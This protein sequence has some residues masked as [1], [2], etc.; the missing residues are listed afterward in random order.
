MISFFQFFTQKLRLS[1]PWR[2]KVPLLISF[3]Y[4]LL[5]AGNVDSFTSAMSFF[6]AIATTIGFMGFGYLTND[7]A[8]RKK[9][10]LA[11]KSNGTANLS[12]G[13]ISMLVIAFLAI[14]ILPWLY[15]PLDEVSAIC[16]FT[17]LA[18]FVL[19]AFPPFRLKERGILGVLTDS[20]YAHV[21][22]GF[23]ASWTFFLVGEKKYDD[24]Y[25]FAG[26]LILW[27]LISGTR[28]IVSHHFKDFENDQ[29][30]GTNT[31]AT[32]VGKDRVYT[33]MSR[34]LI[35]LEVIAFVAFLAVI[36]M[37]VGF[38]FAVVIVFLAFATINYR[39]GDSDT[40]AK[41]F[42]N[43][44]LD[45]FYIHWFPYIIIFTLL[46]SNFEFWW[47][48]V[49]H[50]LLF[51]PFIGR[52]GHRF[53]SKK[54]MSSSEPK[55]EKF[56]ILSTNRNKYSETFIQ[57]HIRLI[58]EVVVYSD[59]YFP[60]SISLDKGKSWKELS[61]ENNPENALIQSWKEQNV[62]AVLAEYGPAGA[63]VMHACQKANLPLIVHFH[64]FDAYREDALNHYGEQYKELFQLA[65]KIMVVSADMKAQL[66]RLGCPQEKLQQITY[67]VDTDVFT[68]PDGSV[69]RKN[70]IACGRF[71]PKKAPLK[72]IQ[73][74]AKV[75]ER[76]PDAK[77]TFVGE[78][79]LLN[80]A[81][82]LTKEL[83]LENQI[84]FKGILSPREVATELQSHA[85][86]VQHSVKTDQNDS[87]GTPLS[88]LEAAATGLAIVST[89]HAGIPEV[90][91]DGKSGYLVQ[92]GDV[93][94]MA[95]RMI[96]LL[97]DHQLRRKFG[98]NARAT[99]VKK[100]GQS[101]YIA[102]LENVLENAEVPATKE[103]RLS[104]WKKRLAVFAVLF[105]LAEIGLRF[106]GYNPG[107][108]E[109][110]Y[111]HK[112]EVVYD[113]ILYADEVGIT[114]IVPGAQ[115]ITD[116]E[117]NTE[118]FMSAVE[119]S[120]ESVEAIRASGQ[121]IVM[122][123]GDSYT[124]G[125]C[126]DSY[127]ASFA[128]LLNQSEEYAVLNFGIP[129]ADPVQYRLIVEKYAPLLKP[130][131]I[132]VAVYG[133]NDILEYD[134]TA[135]PF[136]PLSYPIKNGPWLNSEGPIYL[137]KQG[138]YFKNFNE[139]KE[140][141]FDYFS[142][143][144]E[145]NTFFEKTI[146]YSVILSRPYM[147]W[148]TKQRYEE[149]KDQMPKELEGQPY[150]NQNLTELNT[151]AKTL[152]IPVQ[153]TLIPSPSDVQSKVDLKKKYHFVFSGLPY[154][155]PENMTPEDYDGLADANHFNNV[156]HRKFADFL[157]TLIEPTLT[158]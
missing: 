114:H 154:S 110:Y 87:E 123:I 19:Y 55:P 92:E 29:V 143:W 81:K 98:D 101:E 84:D 112:G 132:L 70:F 24:F 127:N 136:I 77:L 48:L 88:I 74:F 30:S 45:R 49:F 157:T 91:E 122:L 156:G 137:T 34:V 42:T 130:D 11:G 147:K 134:R 103:G 57:A 139:A 96:E 66:L 28:N 39:N 62:K 121:K 20:L 128:Q 67:G 64:G 60:T 117:V 22:P 7:L 104:V 51:H 25:F 71:V 13:S 116:G 144:G 89:K 10:E 133:G 54:E 94:A 12:A 69:E 111:F 37:E 21:V 118:G 73:A 106:V 63:E 79:E 27:Q 44:F 33:L 32:H 31:F 131:L 135:K 102:Q 40:R 108:I 120:Q 155:T 93:D 15:L 153:F 50:F 140:H 2:Y 86:F 43:T 126:A 82:E 151:F 158:E 76:H 113:S 99:I 14:A 124:Q 9:D 59:G 16:I 52:I 90:I 8:D 80:E 78:G 145:E 47:L 36:Q 3:C 53:S 125:C 97:E 119:F 58:R 75:V 5:L 138:T 26:T 4:F 61:S 23:L 152:E 95:A 85:I 100:Y 18:L 72:T 35:P 146:R 109:D 149:I 46:F 56:A 38:L 17:E 65:S 6:A 1:N 68:T 129:G 150:S 83:G 115:L 107:V 142:L 105:I 141:Y 148:K 41:H